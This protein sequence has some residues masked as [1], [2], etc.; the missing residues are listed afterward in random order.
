L[1]YSFTDLLK[2][3]AYKGFVYKGMGGRVYATLQNPFVLTKYD[4]LDPE[5]N[6]GIDNN[7]YPRPIT[8]LLG[9]NLQF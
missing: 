8:F 6:S 4:G 5:L 3:T 2:G 7:I 9:V 1:G